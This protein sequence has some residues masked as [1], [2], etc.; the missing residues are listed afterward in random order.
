[1]PT[2]QPH[3]IRVHFDDLEEANN[4]AQEL[5]SYNG[6]LFT[7][8]AVLGYHPNGNVESEEEFRNGITMGWVNQYHFNGHL[9]RETLCYLSNQNSISFNKYNEYGIKIDSYIFLSKEKYEEIIT[10]YNLLE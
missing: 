5:L 3:K 4:K 1:M 8:Y 9:R 2:K 6:Q 10:K 7:G